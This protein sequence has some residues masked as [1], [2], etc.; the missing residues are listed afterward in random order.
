M[1]YRVPV[2]LLLTALHVHLPETCRI[3]LTLSPV[4][5]YYTVPGV[6]EYSILY[7]SSIPE[8]LALYGAGS[9]PQQSLTGRTPAEAGYR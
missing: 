8:Y 1:Q 7:S 6:P 4:C 2:P 9:F 3:G 5:I